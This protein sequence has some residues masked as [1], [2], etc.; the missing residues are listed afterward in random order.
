VS[1]SSG[2][3][4]ENHPLA[5]SISD[6]S[7]GSPL[8]WAWYVDDT[9]VSQLQTYSQSIF[10]RPGSYTIRLVVTNDY[11]TSAKEQ[12]VTA[13]PFQIT[14][15]PGTITQTSRP[16]T[17]PTTTIT[18]VVATTPVPCETCGNPCV[19][20]SIPC[21]WIDGLIILIIVILVIWYIRRLRPQRR[22]PRPDSHKKPD[23]TGNADSKAPDVTIG[24]RGGIS[25]HGLDV[26]NPD[27][28]MDVEAGIRYHDREE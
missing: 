20:F 7:T 1:P 2:Q 12:Q 22:R 14:T 9:L 10:T 4:Y 26:N 25:S 8:S 23:S 6:K 19:L 5:V 17:N 27:I 13:L 28:H 16:T 18:T 15:T 3:A 24:T 11:G 21:L